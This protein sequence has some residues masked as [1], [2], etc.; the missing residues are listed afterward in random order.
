M[1]LITRQTWRVQVTVM[2]GA[3]PALTALTIQLQKSRVLSLQ[4]GET[5]SGQH[6]VTVLVKL[7]TLSTVSVGSLGLVRVMGTETKMVMVKN[8][9]PAETRETSVQVILLPGVS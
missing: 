8:P 9:P 3:Y 1:H 6:R 5:P 4:S 7:N 2:E